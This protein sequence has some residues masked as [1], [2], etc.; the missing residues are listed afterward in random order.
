MSPGK[1]PIA[2]GHPYPQRRKVT[3]AEAW[4][5]CATPGVKR[6]LTA[7]IVQY[8]RA[9]AMKSSVI[10]AL[11]LASIACAAALPV[12]AGKIAGV[13]VPDTLLTGGKSLQLNGAGV[14]SK[15][16]IDLYVGA[17][18][19][20]ASNHDAAAIVAADEPMAIRLHIV[21][22]LIT[23]EKMEHATREGF[24]NATDGN[25]ADIAEQIEEFV[26]V[27]REPIHEYDIY[28][29]IYTPSHFVEVYRN[30]ELAT[31]LLGLPFKRAMFGIWLSE[32]PAQ[33][34]LKKKMLGS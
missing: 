17:L 11:F 31:T 21:S 19:L 29:L 5:G 3:N 12:Q 27:F 14:R 24:D 8:M 33:K 4:Y 2:Y 18:Y 34:S 1:A 10:S 23:S 16:F 7:D 13:E 22:G 32:H 6:I 15:L 9:R 28:E 30:G 20:T 25:T 26:S